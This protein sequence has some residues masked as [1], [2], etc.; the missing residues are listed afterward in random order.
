MNPEITE[1]AHSINAKPIQDP[2]SQSVLSQHESCWK[3]HPNFRNPNY[4]VLKTEDSVI[5]LIVKLSRLKPRPWWGV[6]KQFIEFFN[7]FKTVKYFLVL[8][9]SEKSGWL[10]S[11]EDII[12]NCKYCWSFSGSDYKINYG[13]LPSDNSFLSSRKFL[14]KLMQQNPSSL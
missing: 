4:F 7:K 13:T 5:V 3:S 10:Y 6:G 8:L 1:F 2:S 9:D 12:N 14:S 11:K